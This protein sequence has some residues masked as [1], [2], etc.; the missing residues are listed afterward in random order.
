[1]DITIRKAIAVILL[2]AYGAL[3]LPACQED[4]PAEDL[5]EKVD[6]AADD[7]GRAVEDAAD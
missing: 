1:M 5:G 7:A 3:A 2:S 6:E 4:G